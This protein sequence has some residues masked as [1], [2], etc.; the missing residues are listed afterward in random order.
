M[1]S[2]TTC[3]EIQLATG[4]ETTMSAVNA[5]FYNSTKQMWYPHTIAS[6]KLAC[7]HNCMKQHYMCGMDVASDCQT[8]NIFLAISL[9]RSNLRKFWS[10]IISHH[11]LLA[12]AEQSSQISHGQVAL[13]E[14]PVHSQWLQWY[15]I[16]TRSS[17][18]WPSISQKQQATNYSSIAKNIIMALKLIPRYVL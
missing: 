16:T 2:W 1:W 6:T 17:S 18:T 3:W 5:W 11:M 10:A 8:T 4:N 15:K 9:P 14:N 7:H 13:V 12:D